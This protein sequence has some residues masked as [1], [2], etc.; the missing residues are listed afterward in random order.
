MLFFLDRLISRLFYLL[1]FLTPLIFW[2]FSSELFEFNKIVFVYLLTA[3]TSA[4]WLIKCILAGKLIFRRTALDI[5]IVVF[6]ASLGIS[7]ILSI[8]VRTSLL[9]Y[10]S[11]FHGGLLSY[12][13]YSILY[14]AFVSN[15]GK[16][17][18][19]KSIFFLIASFVLVLLYGVL[20][21]LGID[22]NIWVQDVQN[23]IFST[24]GQPN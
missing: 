9:G 20:Q 21:H 3:V 15:M 23:R 10:Y 13:S 8:D 17:E 7:T 6:L 5:P 16:G 12:F 1:L 24:L 19:K 11:R 4:L 2:P 18:T 14:W 22:K